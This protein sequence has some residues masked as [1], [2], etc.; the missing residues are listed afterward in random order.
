M[1]DKS[2]SS[3]YGFL[4]GT[5][6]KRLLILNIIL[7]AVYFY[8]LTF[9][10]KHDNIYLFALLIAGEVFHLWQIIGYC[11]TV[12]NM[13]NDAVFDPNFN[14]GV[15]VFITVAGEPVEIVEETARAAM[16]MNYPNF[17]VHI[18]NDGYVAK[19]DNWR[20]VVIMSQ[21]LGINCITR[22]TPGGAKAGNI[23]HGLSKTEHP[24]FVVFDADHVPKPEFLQQV[25][26]YFK[27]RRMGFVQT[28]QFTD[29]LGS[30]VII[31]WAYHER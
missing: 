18:L 27:D 13:R 20:D 7:A 21:K 8:I 2:T 24:Y 22:T 25:M 14:L 16:A 4:E 9:V 23:N 28:P 3:R 5:I 29:F 1:T 30:T 11:Y 6:N 17:K 15:D 12:W 19:R 26:G 10:F 31:L